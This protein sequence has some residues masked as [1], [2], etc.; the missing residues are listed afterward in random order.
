[1]SSAKKKAASKSKTKKSTVTKPIRR[2]TKPSAKPAAKPAK[3]PARAPSR[4]PARGRKLSPAEQRKKQRLA[5]QAKADRARKA[6]NK[7]ARER[8]AEKRGLAEQKAAQKAERREKQRKKQRGEVDERDLAIEWLEHIRD[9]MATVIATSLSFTEPEAGARTPWLIVGRFDLDEECDYA[10]LAQ[11]LEVVE[12]DIILEA[13][14]HPQ[15]LSQIR[16]VYADPHAKRG[17]GDSIVSKIGAWEFIV[18]DLIGEIAGGG[19]ED[20]GALAVRYV[21]TTIPTIYIYF[22]SEIVAHQ[23]A[24]PWQ[25]TQTVRLAK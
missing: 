11:A 20:E 14:I 9:D 1:M 5:A 10:T 19:A 21:E 4:G 8:Y 22:S 12:Q 17:E 2:A 15:R 3:K 23:T 25:T 18:S 16:I 6:K 7:R 24:A 13:K